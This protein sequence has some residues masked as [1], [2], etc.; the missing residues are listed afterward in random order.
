MS[1]KPNY[2]VLPSVDSVLVDPEVAL[3][4]E[5]FNTSLVT[6]LIRSAI[7][8][9][10]ETIRTG[11]TLATNQ[12]NLIR[13]VSLDVQKE[14]DD[15]H[16]FQLRRVINATG[17]VLHTNLGRAPLSKTA[18]DQVVSVA[19]FYSNLEFDLVSG[20]RGSRIE[21]VENLLCSLT[22]ADA[23]LVVN[24][25]AAAVL[26]TLNSLA[27]GLEVLVSRGQLVEIGD[28]FRIPD[29]MSRSGVHLVEVGTTNRTHLMDFDRALGDRSRLLFSVNP[30]NYRVLGFTAEVSLEELVKLGRKRGVPVAHDLGGGVLV[31]LRKFGLPYEPLVSDSIAAGA[32]V[33]TFSADKVLGG[34][35]AGILVGKRETI[36]LIRKNPLIRA[37][38][39]G[40]LTYAA[41]ESTLK[42]YFSEKDLLKVHP[43]LKMLTITVA[44]LRRRGRNLLERLKDLVEQGVYLSLVES[45]AQA[46]SGALPLEEI[47]SVALGISWPGHSIGD[48]AARLR[49][50][51]S[52]VIGY[53][54]E[55]QLILDLRTLRADEL[56][57]VAEVVRW[58]VGE[59]KKK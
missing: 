42:L 24:N 38:R 28:S 5:R 35:Q 40:K 57:I 12:E 55:E 7:D 39:C 56:G 29:I 14:L 54:R 33:V 17:I 4:C 53:V 26:L 16:S 3:L 6:G 1:S 27:F 34:P 48:L 9:I 10:R 50:H 49:I 30:S 22:G 52:P 59:E 32:D 20:G 51:H 11:S 2:S 46:G 19:G 18:V 44:S 58:A 41:L 43:T 21:L 47:P 8:R 31:D 36:D 13:Q 37:L 15:I 45:V 25:N 23:A